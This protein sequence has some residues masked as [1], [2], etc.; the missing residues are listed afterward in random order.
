MLGN[1]LLTSEGKPHD[2]ARKL[3][4]PAFSPRRLAGYTESFAERTRARIDGWRDGDTLDMHDEMA[5]LTLDIVGRTLLGIDLTDRSEQIR[6]S[7]E[8]ALDRFGEVGGGSLLI[9]G[10]GRRRGARAPRTASAGGDGHPARRPRPTCTGS[11]D[12]VIDEHRRHRPSD[13]RGD[14]VS[15]LLSDGQVRAGM[16]DQEIHDHVITLIM[17]GHETTANALTWALFLIGRRPDIQHRLHDEVDRLPAGGPSFCPAC[18][19]AVHPGGDQ[20]GDAAVPT[21]LGARPHSGGPAG[22]RRLARTGRHPG[23]RQPVAAAPRSAVVRQS[24]GVRPG[25]LAR[26]PAEVVAAQRLSAVRHR[27]AGLHRRAVRLGGGGDGPGGDRRALDHPDATGPG[28]GCA[29]PGRPCGRAGRCHCGSRRGMRRDRSRHTKRGCLT[30]LSR[31]SYRGAV[32]VFVNIHEA[33]THL[34]RLLEQVAAGERVIISKA[35]TPIAELVPH[36]RQPV[37]IGGLKGKIALFRRRLGKRGRGDRRDVL[38]VRCS[39]L[40]ARSSSGSP[41]TIRGWA[42]VPETASRTLT[43]VYVS[44]ATIWELTIKKML[45]KLDLPEAF[46]VALAE[47][48]ITHLPVT[49]EHAAGIEE[50]PE[51][52][53]HD[54]FDPP[55]RRPGI[56]GEV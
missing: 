1:G 44:A 13:D 12:E 30:G 46:D 16:T 56:S 50:F 32:T 10:A 55:A 23:R 27:A 17:A 25:S 35:G 14:V 8:A 3:I 51:L 38:R 42:G 45:G 28:A 20:R 11:V 24:R 22:L 36:R 40:T 43:V 54:P 48:G 31:T 37:I 39:F 52:L 2:R 53:R 41:M 6:G 21:G 19:P 47:Q 7:L 18:R 26:R 49:A 15:A 29:V 9:G 5:C 4:A 34:S 33:K